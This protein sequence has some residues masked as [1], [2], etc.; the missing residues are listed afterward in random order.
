MSDELCLF[1]AA[2]EAI[3]LILVPNDNIK[4]M[5]SVRVFIGI[6]LTEILKRTKHADSGFLLT[7]FYVTLTNIYL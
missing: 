6:H 1:Y 7:S 4:S 2:P 5:R 3:C